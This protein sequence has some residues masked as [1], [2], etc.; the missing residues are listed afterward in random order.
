MP[1]VI[2]KLWPDVLNQRFVKQVSIDR[3]TRL[4]GGRRVSGAAPGA[5]DTRKSR[6]SLTSR[7]RSPG[8]TDLRIV[9]SSD[10][11]LRTT[12]YRLAP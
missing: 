5:A 4:Q 12:D 7:S 9:R 2:V 10:F 11:R 6:Y 3:R 8:R 1:H